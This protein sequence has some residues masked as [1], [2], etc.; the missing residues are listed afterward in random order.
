M[1]TGIASILVK[2]LPYQ[3]K[4]MDVIADSIFGLNVILFLVFLVASL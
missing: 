3:F 2:E 4:H 1:G